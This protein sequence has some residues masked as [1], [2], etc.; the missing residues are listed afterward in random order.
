MKP[1]L[2]SILLVPLLAAAQAPNPAEPKATAPVTESAIQREEVLR[3]PEPGRFKSLF[4]PFR[5]DSAALSPDGRYLAYS[6]R[7]N[8]A[9]SVIVIEI[10]HPDEVLSRVQ[11]INDEAATPMLAIN[12]REKTPGRINWLGWVSPT[13]I[14]VETNQVFPRNDGP[15]S[16]WNNWRGA[17]EAFDANGSNAKR[18]ASPSDVPE[19]FYDGS[20]DSLFS[21]T[22]GNS[23]GFNSRVATPDRPM[24]VPGQAGLVET[25]DTLDVSITDPSA[26]SS[27]T[28]AG[29]SEPRTMRVF[30]FDPARPGAI[31][32]VVTG[33]PR[34]SGNHSIEF[35]SLDAQTGKFT[36]LTYDTLLNTRS[37]LLDRQGRIRLTIPSTLLSS[38][39]LRYDYLG[40][41]GLNRPRPLSEIT[42]IDGFTVSPDNYFGARAIPL[43]F[44]ENPNL[45]YYASN[46]TRDTYGI[47]NV[48]LT[49]GQRG[50]L[51]MENPVFDLI[52]PP[53][54]GFPEPSPLVFDRHSQQ[55]AGIRYDNALRTTAWIDAD[56]RA[57]QAEFEKMYPGRSVTI[58]GWDREKK[59]LLV[60]TEGPADP[61]S[62][63][64]FDAGTSRL[65]EFVRRAPWIDQQQ[66]HL[67]LPFSYATKDGARIS[68]LVTAPRQ[69]RIT[70]I[71]V[72]VLCPDQPWL[73]VSSSFQADVQAL[74]D[75]GF[76]VVQLNGRGA[77]GL[78]LKQRL[79]LTT[80]YD[81]V[82]VDDILTTLDGIAKLFKV[83]ARRVALMGRGHGGFIALRALQEHPDRF[84][85]AIAIEAPV[86]LKDW[87]ETQRWSNDDI[88]PYLTRNWLGDAAR[89]KAAPLVSHPERITKPILMLNYPGLDGEPRSRAY[90][91]ASTL[92]GRVK[93]QGTAVTFADLPTDYMQGLPAARAEVFDH[94]EEFLNVNIY[95]FNVRL[96]ELQIIK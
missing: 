36:S 20:R 55:L 7:E 16:T 50:K 27:M 28:N 90:L 57:Y 84:R 62:F 2:L 58:T 33:S 15:N 77:W 78:G 40:P 51:A 68:G 89:L 12:Q 11:V 10:D 93:R 73:R 67:T 80:G 63:L 45:F 82:Q 46:L 34:P 64:V 31:T 5:T 18:I 25:P 35:F 26:D 86:D 37:G 42:G 60:A 79:S 69:P 48:D 21:I 81:L 65:M 1:S 43:G 39:P 3:P 85:C 4:Q 95:D 61:G 47:Y 29:T 52:G 92:A 30:D 91:T 88:Q 83:N 70:P 96:P 9:V 23:S 49:T 72:V 75:M 76:V 32:L 66:T 59:R 22:R 8:D 74:A 56:L 6:V 94:I 13:R 87:L 17:I 44:D 24:P 71:P 53:T 14:A 54:A 38:F 19:F 41:K